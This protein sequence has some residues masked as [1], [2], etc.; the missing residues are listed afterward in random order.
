[1]PSA[2]AGNKSVP[3]SMARIWRTLKASGTNGKFAL[4]MNGINSGMLLEK[5]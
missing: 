5:I 4:T 1:M 3:R 2:S